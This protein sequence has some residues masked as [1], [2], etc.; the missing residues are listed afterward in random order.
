MLYDTRLVFPLDIAYVGRH[1]SP[2]T[3]SRLYSK[4]LLLK[5]LSNALCLYIRTYGYATFPVPMDQ[6]PKTRTICYIA[7][8]FAFYGLFPQKFEHL[9]PSV[10]NYICW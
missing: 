8:L 9:L 1:E 5:I 6:P 3:S 4:S 10:V 7:L 2:I